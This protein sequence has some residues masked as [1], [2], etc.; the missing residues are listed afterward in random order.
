MQEILPASFNM[1]ECTDTTKEIAFVVIRSFLHDPGW[2]RTRLS[3]MR[4]GSFLQSMLCKRLHF[5]GYNNLALWLIHLLLAK[6]IIVVVVVVVVFLLLLSF[7]FLISKN[8]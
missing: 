5:A 6:I 4:K 2:F 3:H 1:H 8:S 7:S